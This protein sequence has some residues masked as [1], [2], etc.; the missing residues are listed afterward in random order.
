VAETHVAAALAPNLRKSRLNELLIIRRNSPNLQVYDTIREFR[1]S[2]SQMNMSSRHNA[3][4][5]VI[6][7]VMRKRISLNHAWMNNLSGPN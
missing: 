5:V 6:Y 7:V 3:V 2:S 4:V 1:N